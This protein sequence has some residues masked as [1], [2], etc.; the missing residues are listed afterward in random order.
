MKDV[1]LDVSKCVSVLCTIY[2]RADG[3]DAVVVVVVAV[4][5]AVVSG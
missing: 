2:A 1:R 3:A 4:C 5:V